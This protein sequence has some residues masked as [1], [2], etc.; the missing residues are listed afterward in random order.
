MIRFVG[1][2]PLFRLNWVFIAGRAEGIYWMFERVP[3]RLFKQTFL[4][5][6]EA[7]PILNETK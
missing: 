3:L 4:W 6:S 7:L 2:W 5:Q 1:N